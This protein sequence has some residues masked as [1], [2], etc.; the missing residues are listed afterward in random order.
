MKVATLLVVRQPPCGDLLRRTRRPSRWPP[1]QIMRRACGEGAAASP[2][3]NVTRVR[4]LGPPRP[5]SDKAAEVNGE[6][7][8]QSLRRTNRKPVAIRCYIA[9]TVFRARA[10][11]VFNDS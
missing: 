5:A 9:N 6:G 1:R 2:L 11:G 8:S 10:D 7:V 4:P 3:T